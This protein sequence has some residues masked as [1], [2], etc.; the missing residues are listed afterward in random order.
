MSRGSRRP[1]LWR[2]LVAVL[3][4]LTIVAPTLDHTAEGAGQPAA[5]GGHA[6]DLCAVPGLSSVAT[7]APRIM[8]GVLL[9]IGP[10]AAFASLPLRSP[11]H[12]PRP[13]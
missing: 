9:A 4:L 2:L 11:D 6:L 7:W 3:A 12:P 13:V 5:G 8:L 10:A 1:R